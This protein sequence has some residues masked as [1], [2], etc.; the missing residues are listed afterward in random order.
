RAGHELRIRRHTRRHILGSTDVLIAPRHQLLAR[1][2]QHVAQLRIHEQEPAFRVELRDADRCR[3]DRGAQYR[4][5][6]LI[7]GGP[8]IRYA[9]T[10][11]P[12]RIDALHVCTLLFAFPVG[13][14]SCKSGTTRGLRPVP[15][16]SL[17]SCCG[18]DL[19]ARKC[20]AGAA[21]AAPARVTP[22]ARRVRLPRSPRPSCP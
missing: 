9:R 5:R 10:T 14:A 1:V 15:T 13:T 7:T 6:L 12:G 19:Y 4:G 18:N 11:A 21:G 8:H 20:G 3:L 22:T 16:R 17:K 2:A